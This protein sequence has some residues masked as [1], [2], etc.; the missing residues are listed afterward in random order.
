MKDQAPPERP[1]ALPLLCFIGG[2]TLSSVLVSVAAGVLASFAIAVLLIHIGFEFRIRLA[3]L[4]LCIGLGLIVG[5]RHQKSQT[6]LE[7]WAGTPDQFS[8]IRAPIEGNWDRIATGYRMSAS[9]FSIEGREF[10][11]RITIYVAAPPPPPGRSGTVVARGFLRLNERNVCTLTCKSPRLIRYQGRAAGWHPRYWNRLADAKLDALGESH[12]KYTRQIALAKALVL[13]RSGELAP[14]IREDY[15]RGGTYHLLVFSGMQIALA[16]AALSLAFRRRGA[17]RLAD[18]SLF[19]LALAAP[20]FAGNEPSVSR[21]SLMI[22]VYAASRLMGRPTPIENLFFVCAFLQL[23]LN[24]NELSDAGFALTYAAT[25]GLL[26]V[27]KPLARLA[28]RHLT[29]TVLY[30]LG[31]EVATVPI[32]LYFFHQAVLGGSLVTI[33]L[34]PLLTLML[35]VAALA[36]GSVFASERATCALLELLGW[37]DQLATATNWFF[38]EVL[39]LARMAAA[40]SGA[41]VAWSV[42]GFILFDTLSRG[43]RGVLLSPLLLLPTAFSF[44]FPL[45]RAEVPWPQVE[46]LDVGQGDAILL[47]SGPAAI[48]VDGGGRH[49]DPEFG[50]RVLMP[51]LLDRGVRRLDAMLLTHP[52]PDHCDGLRTVMALMPV[53]EL[54]IAPNHLREPCAGDLADAAFMRGRTVR[55]FPPRDQVTV[56]AFSFRCF[57]TRTPYKRATLN[58]S[59]VVCEVSAGGRT[60]LLTGDLEKE[61]EAEL[62]P[63]FGRVDVVKLAHHGSRNSSSPSFLRATSPRVAIVSCG[64]R[65]PFGHPHPPLLQRLG[66]A[67]MRIWRTD[68]NGD[69]CVMFREGRVHVS[70]EID[71]F[72]QRP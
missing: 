9:R 22:G 54:W 29:A 21:A 66:Q 40:P 4:A 30:S 41:M 57:A 19:V 49:E 61:A 35:G 72:Q 65:N 37:L 59:S 56:G 69:I 17:I 39:G 50:R 6:D 28:R 7:A 53:A 38:G 42:A 58:N 71:S 36:C 45:L 5:G 70:A 12:E 23:L 44:A 47:R 32:T 64:R 25:G 10:S 24:P 1:A 8:T 18:W 16:A 62:L 68:R 27:G 15:R 34:A 13:G 14:E 48:L 3:I 52:H 2:L 55:L 33:I 63:H 51:K 46:L 67:G 20:L 60:V 43:R 11:R 31:A 26:F